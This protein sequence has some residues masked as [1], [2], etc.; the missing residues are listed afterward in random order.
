MI[1]NPKLQKTVP[2]QSAV[3][4]HVQILAGKI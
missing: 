3:S 4:K 1:R 2:S